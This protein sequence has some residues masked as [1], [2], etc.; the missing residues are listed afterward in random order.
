MKIYLKNLK[1][2]KNDD[3]DDLLMSVK[4]NEFQDILKLAQTEKFNWA[5]V[6]GRILLKK[7]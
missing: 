3:F 1:N 2:G 5:Y 7:V 6:S 4:L